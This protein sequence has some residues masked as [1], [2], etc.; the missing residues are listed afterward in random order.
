[1]GFGL[2]DLANGLQKAY[3]FFYWTA[4]FLNLKGVDCSQTAPKDLESKDAQKPGSFRKNWAGYLGLEL[5]G[6]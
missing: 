5:R 2:F 1:M 3:N 6:F 4:D